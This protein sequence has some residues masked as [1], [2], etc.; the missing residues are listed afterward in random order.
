[1]MD[2]YLPKPLQT[3]LDALV[4]N[5]TLSSWKI[6]AGEQ[7]IQVTI[8]FST[9]LT[10]ANITNVKYRKASPSRILRDNI[11][12][13]EH[14]EH[15]RDDLK[16]CTV[17]DTSTIIPETQLITEFEDTSNTCN[18]HECAWKNIHSHHGACLQKFIAPEDW[19]TPYCDACGHMFSDPDGTLFKCFKCEDYCL[20]EQCKNRLLHMHHSP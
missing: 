7:F 16:E 15:T 11:R 17:K 1:M 14:Q 4:V 19:T 18:S 5:N 13:K 10:D 6:T 3:T 12:A 9:T 8:R 20:C 2:T